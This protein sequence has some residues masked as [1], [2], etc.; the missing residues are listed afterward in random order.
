MENFYKVVELRE[1][2]VNGCE[3]GRVKFL[4]LFLFHF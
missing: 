4:F 3:K 2:M 1:L